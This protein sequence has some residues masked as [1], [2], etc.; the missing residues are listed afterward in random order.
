VAARY[1][2]L[3][4]GGTNI[5]YAVV[6]DGPEPRVVGDGSTE[7]GAFEGP[8]AVVQRMIEV[9]REAVERHGPIE[10]A[11][12]GVPGVLDHE[13]GRALFLPNLP[14]PWADTPLVQP[15]AKALGAPVSLINDA[16]AFTL[17]ELRLGAGRG[18]KDIL[19]VGIGTGIGG[20]VA[21]DG[22]LHLGLDGT[23]GEFG[24]MT[25]DPDGPRC[26]CGNR[27][28]VEVL[29]AGP[30]IARAGH[31]A[32]PELVADA[33]RHGDPRAREALSQ[34]GSLIG[35]AVANAIV[36]LAPQRVII[37]GGVAA[38]GDLLLEPIRAEVNR[39][40][41]VVPVER[42]EIV[43]AELGPFAGAVG[44]A[45]WGAEARAPR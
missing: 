35:I 5:K 22:R 2:G 19:C 8:P 14:G 11:G 37:G 16:R 23:A 43:R 10:G 31:R 41:F 29:A 30:A 13:R 28:C 42:I 15:L 33:A 32:T 36:L 17:G 25:V 44:A 7:T 1:L 27:G 45:L 34:A 21:I 38:A 12:T 24:H 6:E 4:L 18:C 26:P 9:G 20:G 39:R 3:D 40:V